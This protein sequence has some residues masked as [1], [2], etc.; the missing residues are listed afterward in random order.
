MFGTIAALLVCGVLI[1][2]GISLAFNYEG[3]TK[4]RHRIGVAVFVAGLLAVIYCCHE[5]YSAHTATPESIGSVVAFM[6]IVAALSSWL[7]YHMAVT[8]EVRADRE[9]R[10]RN[11]AMAA[12]V[13]KPAPR[14]RRR[15]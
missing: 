12:V 7:G 6:A 15:P 9:R 14:V 4:P 10:V 13:C 8:P 5:R 1:I 11:A 2:V 3:P